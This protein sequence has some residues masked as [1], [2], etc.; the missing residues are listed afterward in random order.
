MFLTALGDYPLLARSVVISRL[1]PVERPGGG[2][3]QRRTS[4]SHVV[5]GSPAD[6]PCL[7]PRPAAANPL[8]LCTAAAGFPL[9]L[10]AC[11]R[12]VQSIR[13]LAVHDA[14]RLEIDTPLERLDRTLGLGTE[15]PIAW[16][17]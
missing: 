12:V 3:D 9:V 1:G 6:S 15:H 7:I 2:R 13:R 8:R 5:H 10:E 17:G 14:S 11:Q 4:D 16:P